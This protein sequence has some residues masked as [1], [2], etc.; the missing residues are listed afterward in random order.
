[1][2]K[3]VY[4]FV[5]MFLLLT[6][7]VAMGDEYCKSYSGAFHGPCFRFRNG[8]CNDKC[9]GEDHQDYGECDLDQL[10]CFCYHSCEN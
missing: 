1:M 8:E 3:G 7:F 6:A 9:M 2:A 5:M 10:V 4:V